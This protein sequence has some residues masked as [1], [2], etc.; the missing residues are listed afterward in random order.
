MQ[1]E[2][3][4][5]WFTTELKKNGILPMALESICNGKSIAKTLRLYG[6]YTNK[7]IRIGLLLEN[8]DILFPKVKKAVDDILEP[9]AK[10]KTIEG[11]P[12]ITLLELARTSKL[13]VSKLITTLQEYPVTIEIDGACFKS[14]LCLPDYPDD[15][16]LTIKDASK[17]NVSPIRL[18]RLAQYRS[19]LPGGGPIQ[20]TRTQE[21][22]IGDILKPIAQKKAYI[23][24]VIQAK[25]KPNNPPLAQPANNQK[26]EITPNYNETTTVINLGQLTLRSD[27]K[28]S[29]SPFKFFP[30]Y[31]T[32]YPETVTQALASLFNEYNQAFA[33]LVE[34]N[35]EWSTD[36][37]YCRTPDG[38]V[39]NRW[40]QI[41][42]VGLTPNFL[43]NA[44]G[45]SLTAA[46]EQLRTGIFELENSVAMYQLSM[47]SF[48]IEG[49]P[50]I[51][52]RRFRFSL[53]SLRRKYGK[54]IALLATTNEKYQSI[55]KAEFGKNT[56]DQLTEEEVTAL[57]GFNQ[58]FGPEEFQQYLR[59]NRGECD[60]LLYVR[61]S[62]PVVKLRNPKIAISNPL[63]EN[64]ILR[65]I[66]KK[67][68]ITFNIDNPAW[69]LTDPRR[70]NDTKAYF[71]NMRLGYPITNID[72]LQPTES[73]LRA[74]PLRGTYGCYGHLRGR[75]NDTIFR[76]K[77]KSELR[78]R[79]DYIVQPELQVPL[80]KGKE[81]GIIYA[82]MDRV[83]LF[84]DGNVC[85]FMGGFRYL[86]PTTSQEYQRG[87]MHASAET[88]TAE[89]IG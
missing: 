84:T 40:I 53:D 45:L 61:S 42:M 32:Q 74:K 1:T 54:P 59:K 76:Q 75:F 36:Y 3:L 17:Y 50:S 87:R 82:Y 88:I 66:I 38:S 7:E 10:S 37:Q 34:K 39:L 67:N 70:I 48:P 58:L 5:P 33:E 73:I 28:S 80:L 21:K 23:Q 13:S 47:K 62:D 20:K 51:F 65:R 69:P 27:I 85:G 31:K 6:N 44:A 16:L 55:R 83:F 79:G 71:P 26:T 77:L 12:A 25:L 78:R 29:E 49:Q 24:F 11:L 63:L 43:Q 72:N 2:Q 8:R 56:D 57:S 89:I 81:D 30:E 19:R 60:Y 14:E 18:T 9:W 4:T 46:A 15:Q 86:M 64:T 41:D 52:D 68:S 22:K 35:T